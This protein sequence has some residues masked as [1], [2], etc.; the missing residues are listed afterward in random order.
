[1]VTKCEN[2]DS[3]IELC[4]YINSERHLALLFEDAATGIEVWLPRSLISYI[5]REHK[6]TPTTARIKLPEWLAI[7][8]GLW[9]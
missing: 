4:G 6:H 1:M 9:K 7:R 2:E 8:E 3:H 5:W